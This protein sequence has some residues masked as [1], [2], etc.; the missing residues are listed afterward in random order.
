[1]A[2]INTVQEAVEN[3]KD[4]MKIMTAGFLGVGAPLK[5]IDALAETDVKDLTLIQA[6]SAHPGETHDVGKLV[7]NKQIKK[8][9]GAHIGTCPEIQEQYNAG[10]LEVEFIPMGTIVECI[11]AGGAGLGAVITPTGLGT[12]IEKGR[13]KLIVDGKEYLVFPSIKADIALIKGYKADKLGNIVYRGTTKGTNT[14]MALAADLVIAEVD[15]IVEVGEIPPDSVGTP[16]ILV[17]IIVQGDSLEDRTKY[18]EDLWTRTKKM[19]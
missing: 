9:I 7:A 1:M 15:E 2:K 6:V 12:E 17:D 18:F 16:G 8:F 14:S 3:I 11:R 10:T 4:G 19:K 13:D 5:M